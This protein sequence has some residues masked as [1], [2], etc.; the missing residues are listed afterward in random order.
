MKDTPYEELLIV[1]DNMIKL[2]RAGL[3][4]WEKVLHRDGQYRAIGVNPQLIVVCLVSECGIKIRDNY[5]RVYADDLT[6]LCREIV[7]QVRQE[8]MKMIEVVE[9]LRS[10]LPSL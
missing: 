4:R 8:E 7:K 3:L 1:I 5:S 10:T 2:T 9:L 6:V